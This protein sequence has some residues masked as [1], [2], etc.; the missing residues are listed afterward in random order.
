MRSLHDGC[1]FMGTAIAHNGG[2]G[3]EKKMHCQKSP[4]VPRHQGRLDVVMECVCGVW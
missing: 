1:T 3:V 4:P 2:R